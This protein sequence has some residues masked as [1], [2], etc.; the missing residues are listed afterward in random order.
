MQEIVFQKLYS[1]ISITA[2]R[3]SHAFDAQSPPGYEPDLVKKNTQKV[4]LLLLML[5]PVC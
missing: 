3:I 2:Q 1:S 5:A 4:A